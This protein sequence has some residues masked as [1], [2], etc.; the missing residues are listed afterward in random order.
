MTKSDNPIGDSKLLWEDVHSRI[1]K[2]EI[3]LGDAASAAYVN[4]PKMIAFMASR[5]KFV[6]KML[7]RVETAI[8]VGCGDGFGAPM[9]A[10]SV[11]RLVCT[12]IKESTLA[13][14][15]KRLSMFK[16][17]DFKYFDFRSS[18]FPAKADAV[19]AVD[20]I[21]HIYP[22][23]ERSLIENIAHS[24]VSH[25]IGLFGTP[26]ITADKYASEYS[27][28]GHVNLKDHSD[29][30]DLL[31]KSFHNVFLF[32]MNDEVVH[33]GYYPM[34]HYLWALCTGPRET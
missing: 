21:E 34:A 18:S 5:Y 8:E 9:V 25:G 30:R 3:R 22:S 11:G 10:Q 15:A 17:I 20:V 12:D 26:N 14:N 33:T 7:D 13:D 19:F 27:R 2:Y 32:S 24:L 23:E 4:D 31:S 6:A 1:P 16:N 29:L 28:L